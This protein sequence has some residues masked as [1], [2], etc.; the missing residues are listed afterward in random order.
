MSQTV[1]YALVRSPI[2]PLAGR[3]DVASRTIPIDL[4]GAARIIHGNVASTVSSERIFS[5]SGMVLSKHR[6]RLTSESAEKL[7]VLRELMKE[8]GM[9][10]ERDWFRNLV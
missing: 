6:S 7:V 9:S 10:D 2:V 4:S 5:T 3:S 1:G 8:D